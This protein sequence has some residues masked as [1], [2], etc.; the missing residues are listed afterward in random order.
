VRSAERL[1]IV[2]RAQHRLA[3][4]A[5][6][7]TPRV[8]VDEALDVVAQGQTAA[9]LSQQH[10]AGVPGAHDDRGPRRRIDGRSALLPDDPER[11]PNADHEEHAVDRVQQEDRPRWTPP[12]QE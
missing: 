2:D 3:V 5:Q 7:V 12:E 8:V 4:D 6:P 1:Q 9:E 11:E 10:L